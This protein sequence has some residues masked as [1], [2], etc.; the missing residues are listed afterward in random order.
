MTTFVRTAPMAYE[1]PGSPF[2]GAYFDNHHLD[3]SYLGNTGIDFGAMFTTE[4]TTPTP[5]ETVSHEALA[6]QLHDFL[7]ETQAVTASQIRLFNSSKFLRS[8]L[9]A[10]TAMAISAIIEENGTYAVGILNELAKNGS[11]VFVSTPEITTPLELIAINFKSEDS[12]YLLTLA[13][14]QLKSTPQPIAFVDV[15]LVS[16]PFS[17]D[18]VQ[19]SLQVS[20][21]SGA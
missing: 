21:E 14:Q 12:C 15:P 2:E 8:E 19:F 11:D 10:R 7:A 20:T 13:K 18:S 9:R 6:Q 17:K 1:W 16:V 3:V 4:V 5:Q